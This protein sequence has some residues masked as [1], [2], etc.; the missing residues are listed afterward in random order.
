MLDWLKRRGEA[1]LDN[2]IAAILLGG[3]I[4][5]LV[6][7]G[8][9]SAALVVWAVL[10][11]PEAPS[12]ALIGIG[13]FAATVLAHRQVAAL[14][15]DRRRRQPAPQ[16]KASKYIAPTL[17]D[18]FVIS[19]SVAWQWNEVARDM[20]GPLC[21]VRGHIM[22]L[23]Y[24]PAEALPLS[25]PQGLLGLGETE[26]SSPLSPALEPFSFGRFHERPKKSRAPLESDRVGG[27]SGGKLVCAK[28][29]K[30]R[31]YQLDSL[32]LLGPGTTIG[33]A[34]KLAL[35]EYEAK[36]RQRQLTVR[37]SAPDTEESPP[38]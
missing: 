28:C 5:S 18:D 17:G 4:V 36:V 12:I 15:M 23:D 33:Q 22:A 14:I 20:D 21:P 29:D 35:K 13:G 31:G 26:N 1:L 11:S 2:A 9:V 34:R 8:A 30:K 19:S 25:K 38:R 24:E 7:G 3:L 6:L 37:P 10:T 27:L 16:Q 32:N